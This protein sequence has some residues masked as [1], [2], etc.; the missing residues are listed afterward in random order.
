[1]TE[2]KEKD[3]PEPKHDDQKKIVSEAARIM[4]QA[5][6]KH[7]IHAFENRGT[8]AL[9]AD[10]RSV[11]I[12]LRDQFKSEPGRLEYRERLAAQLSMMLE[13]AFSDNQKLAKQGRSIWTSPPTQRMGTYL[14][15]LIRLLDG[16]PKDQ[17]KP[18]N[19]LNRRILI[20]S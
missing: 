3:T 14:N 12:Q 7:G 6:R 11:Y 1:M 16:W 15:S 13:L 17:N 5:S 18:T 8:A 4:G 20:K 2:N 10:Q 19:I 9:D